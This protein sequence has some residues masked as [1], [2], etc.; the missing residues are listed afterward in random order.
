MNK[1]QSKRDDRE[2]WFEPIWKGTITYGESLFF[3]RYSEGEKP[4][5]S[6][7]FPAKKILKMEVPSSHGMGQ[8]FML[9]CADNLM[10]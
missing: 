7:L 4:K 6:L 5:S 8:W 9:D 1:T 2:Q 10:L 3:I